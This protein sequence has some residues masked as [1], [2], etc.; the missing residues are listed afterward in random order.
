MDHD[1]D[2]CTKKFEEESK[3]IIFALATENNG[4]ELDQIQFFVKMRCTGKKW[5]AYQEYLERKKAEE[6]LQQ[7]I[8]SCQKELQIILQ[9]T[10]DTEIKK[11]YPDLQV[12]VTV[13]CS[14][15]PRC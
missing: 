10:G 1:H 3:R 5:E 15:I 8:D 9:Q 7:R 2:E 4:D 13:K 14:P 12:S 6:K 11:F